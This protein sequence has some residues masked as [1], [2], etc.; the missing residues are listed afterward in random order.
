MFPIDLSS[1]AVR[2]TPFPCFT[3]SPAISEELEH[4]LL[5]WFENGAPWKLAVADFYEQYELDLRDVPDIPPTVRP[6]FSSTTLEY[7][8]AG[9][10]ALLNA[11]LGPQIDIT[12]HKLA[13]SQKIRIH[14]DAR[15][16]G[17]THRL[18]IQINRGWDQSWGGLLMLFK[19]AKVNTLTEVIAPLS[20]SAFG[21]EISEA[22]HHAVSE[23]YHGHR[24]TLV[25][26]FYA[27][28]A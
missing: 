24:Y 22:S 14:N 5:R 23:V 1:A 12:A 20:R 7:L 8:R 4:N 6:L 10:G 13:R 15:P 25:F 27:R 21:F 11:T 2:S 18:L 17:E 16:N 3:L 9:V 19:G 28:R 26:S